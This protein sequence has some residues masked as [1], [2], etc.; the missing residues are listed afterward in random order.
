MLGRVSGSSTQ[1]AEPKIHYTTTGEIWS[2]FGKGIA[3][4]IAQGAVDLIHT[5][6]MAIG[7]QFGTNEDMLKTGAPNIIG[8]P[9]SYWN[10]QG[11]DIGPAIC[12]MAG[13]SIS[14][15]LGKFSRETQTTAVGRYMSPTELKAMKATG[16]V[17]ESISNR[18]VT[19]VTVPPNPNLY[20]AAP[21]GDIFVQFNVPTSSLNAAGTGT[22]KIYGPNSIF[23][24]TLG[25]VEMP[26][27]TSIKIP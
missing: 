3:Q 1:T 16:R 13:G 23:G 22:A 11:R 6:G 8:S 18:G 26:P 9:S 10:K 20:R 7:T 19:S 5:V 24:P 14:G 25:I 27:A 4:S 21:P 15:T 12:V 17:Q 2:E